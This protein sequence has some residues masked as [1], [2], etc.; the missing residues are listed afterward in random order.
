MQISRINLWPKTRALTC[1][2]QSEPGREAQHRA[3]NSLRGFV[4][5]KGDSTQLN[6]VNKTDPH[7][8]LLYL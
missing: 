3:R 7:G 4:F 8:K 1:G 2:D 5:V 6:P